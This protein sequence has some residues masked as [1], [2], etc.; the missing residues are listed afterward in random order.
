MT[1]N[2]IRALFQ[3]LSPS[4]AEPNLSDAEWR[5]L[6]AFADRTQITLHLRG[7]RGLP[8]WLE[9]EIEA[10]RIRNLERRR[11][12]REAFGEL[13]YAFKAAGV[14][15]VVLKGFTHETGFGIDPEA[16]VQY[17]LDLLCAPDDLLRAGEALRSLRYFPHIGRS[18]NDEHSRPWI[19]PS[20]WTWRG[21]YFDPYIPIS[22]EMHEA[23]WNP[24]RDRIHVDTAAFWKRRSGNVLAAV[25]RAGFAALHVLRHVLRQDAKPA[26]TYELARLL[27]TQ[28]AEFW[29]HWLQRDPRLRALETVGFRFASVWFGSSL[30]ETVE[31]EWHGLPEPVS[32]WFDEFAWSPIDNLL[33][34]N[35]DAVWLHLALLESWPDRVRVFCVRVIPVRRPHAGIFKRLR[36]HAA[37]LAP[38][39]LSGLRWWWRRRA[40]S[41]ASQ[42]PDWNRESV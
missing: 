12:L 5:E 36:Y 30:P 28:S 26:H 25:D 7:K 2:P 20:T 1:P 42:I 23:F 35:K 32:T 11:L 31:K 8:L 3:L 22:V 16:R 37:A 41:T 15:Y 4:A 38:A 29:Q 40:V 9:T 18:L 21:D 33:G 27:Q 14:E 6:L 13:D 19:R 10:R 34:S 17:D 39:L 24:C